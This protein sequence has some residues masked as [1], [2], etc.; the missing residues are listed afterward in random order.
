L[1]AYDKLCGDARTWLAEGWVD[2]LAPQLYWPAADKPHAFAALLKWWAGQNTRHRLLLAGM[3]V[4]GWAGI[5]DEA[6]ETANEIALT[7]RQAGTSGEILWHSTLL[8]AHRGGVA[9]ALRKGVYEEPALVPA[10]G[11]LGGAEPARPVLTARQIGRYI[12]LKWKEDAGRAWQWVV[13]RKTGGRWTTE[14][15]PGTQTEEVV[16]AEAGI[17]DIIAIS[18]VNRY[19]NL[20]E[21]AMFH[22]D[23]LDK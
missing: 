3:R 22:T 7:R 12:T 21:A 5:T 15:L 10:C 23:L 18:A 4:G 9:E 8:P 6:R 16:P 13:R 14:I 2:Y 1:D 19:G 11:W 20:S 17:N